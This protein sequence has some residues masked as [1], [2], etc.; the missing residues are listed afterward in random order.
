[1]TAAVVPTL[2]YRKESKSRSGMRGHYDATRGLGLVR[3]CAKLTKLTAGVF[4]VLFHRRTSA[5]QMARSSI[6][7]TL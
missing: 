3:H 5:R 4:D 6:D 2:R 7:C 1:M